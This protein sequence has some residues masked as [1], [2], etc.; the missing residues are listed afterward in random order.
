M[1]RKSKYTVEQKIE[2]VLDYKKGKRS[3]I[4][5][6]SDLGLYKDGNAVREWEKVYDAYDELGLLAKERN[7][8]YTKEFEKLVV[9][10]YLR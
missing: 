2:A 5:I 7:N 10:D 1:S 6:C 9:K 3:A 4:Q 8:T